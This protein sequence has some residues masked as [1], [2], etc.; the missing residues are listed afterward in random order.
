[1]PFKMNGWGIPTAARQVK[2]LTSIHDDVGSIPGLAQGVKDPALLWPWCRP[3]AAALIGPLAWEFPYAVGLAVKRK[4]M[5]G[6]ESNKRENGNWKNKGEP[7]EV[8]IPST[9]W[10]VLWSCRAEC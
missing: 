8:T 10:E 3:A 5:D 4:K 7:G 2:N 6:K 9:P 1:M